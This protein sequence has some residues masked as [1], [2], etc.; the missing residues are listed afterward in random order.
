MFLWERMIWEQQELPWEN[1]LVTD[2]YVVGYVAQ[3]IAIAYNTIHTGWGITG[4]QLDAITK[5]IGG[6]K[7]KPLQAPIMMYNYKQLT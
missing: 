4:S 3:P 7:E 2:N 5:A 1:L 6:R